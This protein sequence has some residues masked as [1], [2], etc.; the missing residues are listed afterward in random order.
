M[1]HSKYLTKDLILTGG[2]E[3][4]IGI[5]FHNL[6]DGIETNTSAL[7]FRTNPKRVDLRNIYPLFF[8]GVFNDEGLLCPIFKK[9]N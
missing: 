2:I 3:T 4:D 9:G 5:T 8:D 6:H 1:Y 7:P